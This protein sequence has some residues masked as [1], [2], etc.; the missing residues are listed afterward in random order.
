MDYEQDLSA[1]VLGADGIF[2][3]AADRKRFEYVMRAVCNDGQC[4]AL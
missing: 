3:R 1:D 4:L 2:L